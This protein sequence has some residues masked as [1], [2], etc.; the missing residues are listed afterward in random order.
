LLDCRLR[1]KYEPQA[2]LLKG[3]MA[4]HM[5]CFGLYPAYYTRSTYL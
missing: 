1:K 4:C 2:E 5:C 3:K